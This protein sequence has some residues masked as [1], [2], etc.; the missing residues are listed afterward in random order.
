GALVDLVEKRPALVVEQRRDPSAALESATAV[1]VR[2]AES[3]HHTVECDHRGGSELHDRSSLLAASVV[4][5]I[6]RTAAPISS[7]AA[8]SDGPIHSA[9]S[10]N[11]ARVGDVV[12]LNGPADFAGHL[13]AS[14]QQDLH[15]GPLAHPYT[16]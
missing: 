13:R 8:E 11:T 16:L 3:L 2:P 10:P 4:V 5:R 12:L 15:I 7:V 9:P 14:L 1:L 6:Y